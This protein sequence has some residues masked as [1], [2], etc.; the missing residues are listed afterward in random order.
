MRK[1]LVRM[2]FW[3]VIFLLKTISFSSVF[4]RMIYMTQRFKSFTSVKFWGYD[5]QQH[6]HLP[7][8][9]IVTK[10]WLIMF[11]DRYSL[12]ETE[13]CLHCK[14]DGWWPH[15]PAEWE[16]AVDW[17]DCCGFVEGLRKW[18]GALSYLHHGLA[19]LIPELCWLLQ[20]F[21]PVFNEII[22]IKGNIVKWFYL[23][24]C[25]S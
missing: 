4:I 13:I 19:W 17:G 9:I 25:S 10:L 3:G 23:S 20:I 24:T 16:H 6:P 14:A 12:P 1:V 18:W 2:Y 5:F 7:K 15:T 8:H 21:S 11:K 22:L